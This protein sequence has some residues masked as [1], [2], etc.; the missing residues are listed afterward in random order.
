[1]EIKDIQE[2]IHSLLYSNLLFQSPVLSGNM[3]A[4]IKQN[5]NYEIVIE[6]PFYAMNIWKEQGIIV[7]INRIING[8]TDYAEWVNKIGAFGTHNKSQHWVNATILGVATVIAQE[9]G[10]DVINDL[11]QE[12]GDEK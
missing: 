2:K 5:G 7:H 3:K 9:I 6:A 12:I 4:H 1:M 8:K 10:A 11:T